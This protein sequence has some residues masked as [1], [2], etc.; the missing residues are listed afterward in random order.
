MQEISAKNMC[1]LAK[2]YMGLFT[3]PDIKFIML[4]ESD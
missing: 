2:K 3:F 4:E 1:I